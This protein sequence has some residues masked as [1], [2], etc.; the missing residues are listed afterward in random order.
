MR[1]SIENDEPYDKSLMIFYLINE[2]F[3]DVGYFDI[4]NTIELLYSIDDED[5]KREIYRMPI[6]L[7]VLMIFDKKYGYRKSSD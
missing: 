3:M 5:F 6:T 2:N 7:L 1:K 4:H